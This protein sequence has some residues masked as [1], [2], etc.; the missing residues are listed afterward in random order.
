[1]RARVRAFERPRIYHWTLQISPA[2]FCIGEI[3][4][5]SVYAL[6]R[7]WTAAPLYIAIDAGNPQSFATYFQ[8]FFQKLIRLRCDHEPFNC[9]FVTNCIHCEDTRSLGRVRSR[10]DIAPSYWSTSARLQGCTPFTSFALPSGKFISL[11]L[12]S[13]HARYRACGS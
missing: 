1:M 11:M 12:E 2:Q 9:D 5:D 3:T 8:A 6:H 13:S 10:V 7:S 4:C